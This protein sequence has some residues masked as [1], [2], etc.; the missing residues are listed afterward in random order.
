MI[1]RDLQYALYLVC[2]SVLIPTPSFAQ[3]TNWQQDPTNNTQYQVPSGWK[4]N[5]GQEQGVYLWQA[6]ED[7]GNALGADISVMSMQDFPN[8]SPDLF[9]QQL[10]NAV[11]GF[12]ILETKQISQDEYHYRAT[13]II[14]GR[15]VNSNLIFLR[16]RNSQFIYLASFSAEEQRYAQ[17]GGPAVLYQSLQRLNPFA[18]AATAAAPSPVSSVGT[19]SNDWNMQSTETQR[20]LMAQGITPSKKALVGEWLQSFSYQTG[21]A[22]QNVVSG[23]ISYGE[24]GYGHFFNFKADGTYTLTYKYNSVSQGCPYKAD[25]SEQGRYDVQGRNL[26]LRASWYE[27]SYNVCGQISPEKNTNP[28]IRSFEVYVDQETLRLVI[29]G[30][31]LEYSASVETANNGDNYIQEGFNKVK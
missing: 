27:G 7:P 3:I 31:P 28:P 17:L 14:E 23:Q 8:S 12:A 11:E 20:Y 18:A 9:L 30:Q 25:F 19:H 22:T 13:G 5:A 10:K 16:D 4:V 29:V 24:R 26:L 1:T 15:K 21:T 6:M 2:L